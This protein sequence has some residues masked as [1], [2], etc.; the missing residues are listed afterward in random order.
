MFVSATVPLRGTNYGLST[1]KNANREPFFEEDQAQKVDI[2]LLRA[3]TISTCQ[4]GLFR[5]GLINRR[6]IRRNV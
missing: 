6:R 2:Q 1:E 3:V 5:D 4:A